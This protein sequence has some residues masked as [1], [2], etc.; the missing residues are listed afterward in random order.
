MNIFLRVVDALEW[1]PK[2]GC[3]WEA[4]FV[5]FLRHWS[6]EEARLASEQSEP[7]NFDRGKSRSDY[8]FQ[9]YFEALDGYLQYVRTLFCYSQPF[10][11]TRE[12]WTPE[13]QHMC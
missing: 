3:G 4:M 5:V 2:A 6:V 10:S 13:A 9:S 8:S 7:W 1:V 12:Q 11:E